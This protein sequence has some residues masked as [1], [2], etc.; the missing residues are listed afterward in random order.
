MRGSDAIHLAEVR[1]RQRLSRQ[2][3]AGRRPGS[4][5]Y[6]PG[7]GLVGRYGA[8]RADGAVPLFRGG[9][10]GPAGVGE[11]HMYRAFRI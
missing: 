6:S 11:R 5:S 9:G 3:E 8:A 7:D 1:K 10:G 2:M 4:L